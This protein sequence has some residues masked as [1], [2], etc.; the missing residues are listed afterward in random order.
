[1]NVGARRAVPLVALSILISVGARHGAPPLLAQ[2][3]PY[4]VAN[5]NGARF[6]NGFGNGTTNSIATAISDCTTLAQPCVVSVPST[7]GTTELV[8]GGAPTWLGGVGA[9]TAGNIWVRDW[10]YGEYDTAVEPVGP[11]NN[12]YSWKQWVENLY[13]PRSKMQD[14]ILHAVN[15]RAFDGGHNIGS[16]PTGG[17]YYYD[18]TAWE[19]ADWRQDTYTPGENLGHTI[20][21]NCY[22][23]GDCVPFGTQVNFYGGS[24]AAGDESAHGDGFSLFQGTT[25]YTGTISSGGSTGSTSLTMSPTAGQGTQGAG[26]FLIDTTSGKTISAGTISAI[27]CPSYCTYTGSGTGWSV[28]TVNTTLGTAVTAP[29]SATVSPGSMNGITAGEVCRVSDASSP[30]DIVIGSTTSSTFTAVFT[31]PHPSTAILACGG[32]SSYYIEL[33]ADRASPGGQTMR[34]LWPIIRSTSSTSIDVWI[35]TQGNWVGSYNGAWTASGTNTYVAYQGA[36]VAS[37]QQNGQL[38]NA[39]TLNPNAAAW[40]NGDTVELQPYPGFWVNGRGTILSKW[41]PASSGEAGESVW[42]YGLWR[43]P[44]DAAAGYV[45]YASLNYYGGTTTPGP[46]QPPSG[47]RFSGPWTDGL[48]FD[49]AP[50]YG[51]GGYAVRLTGCPYTANGCSDWAGIIQAANSSGWDWLTY[52]GANQ[53]FNLSAGNRSKAYTFGP[54]LFSVPVPIAANGNVTGAKMVGNGNTCY[55]SSGGNVSM[56]GWGSTATFGPCSGVDFAFTVQVNSAG[57]GQTANPTVTYTFRNGAWPNSGNYTC[58]MTGGTGTY[59]FVGV[60][61]GTSSVTFFYVGTPA[62]SATYVFTCVGGGN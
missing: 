50:A 39:L 48:R 20:T 49:N 56:S 7:Y 58:T 60:N 16:N 40:A 13:Q 28:S 42:L 6:A 32:M 2:S 37:V 45:N 19:I 44:N 22:S 8:P 53:Q 27:S 9:N 18:K 11:S 38:S 12:L 4:V 21:M 33:V 3:Q 17:G 43:G 54:S 24:T 41:F 62:A 10:R 34:W 57:T 36:R 29:G 26:R 31:W 23:N 35:S 15:L 25:V 1:M 55:T 30:D 51:Q 5:L 52:D 61:Q 59:A 47:I 14:V 46:F